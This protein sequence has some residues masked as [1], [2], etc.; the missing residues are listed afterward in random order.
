MEYYIVQ[1]HYNKWIN[2]VWVEVTEAVGV[3][4]TQSEAENFVNI[5]NCPHY[6]KNGQF[7]GKLTIETV[8]AQPSIACWWG[9][10]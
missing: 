7:V 5:H 2:S 9:K 6:L 1:H 4:K 3:F 8:S 10:K